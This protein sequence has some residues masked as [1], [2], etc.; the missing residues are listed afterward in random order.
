MNLT[1]NRKYQKIIRKFFHYF[2]IF[3]F[4][5]SLIITAKYFNIPE[6]LKNILIWIENLG[7]WS[8]ITF[9]IIYNLATLLLIPGSVLTLGSGIIFGVVWGSIY[10]FIAST[11]GA[12]IAFI[13]GRYISRDW[14]CQ[15]LD[16]HPQ[17]E[18]IDK[19]VVKEGFK[20]V[21][22]ARLCPLFPFNLLNYAFGLMQVSLKDYILGSLGMIPGTVMYV[23][24]GYLVGDIALIG[25][26]Q[27]PTIFAA[28]VI[29]WS[30]NIFGFIATV[31][32]TIYISR[33]AKK[34][35]EKSVAN[36]Q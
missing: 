1:I 33:L 15:Q 25:T 17:F 6:V 3:I 21:F 30:I 13:V 27:Q 34:A 36:N 32:V 29:K 7:L 10:V 24:L 12:T 16:K 8:P 5:A 26:S 9:I 35:L 18:A 4:V 11:L 19:A 31:I 14:V 23:Y 22:L 28:E 2:I 20:I